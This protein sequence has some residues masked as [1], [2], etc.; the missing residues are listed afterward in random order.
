MTMNEGMVICYAKVLEEL[1]PDSA[2]VDAADVNPMRFAQN[3]RRE[4]GRHIKI[5]SEHKAD[6]RYPIVSAASILAKVKRDEE[7]QLLEEQ[8]GQEIGSG[9]PS[10]VRTQRFLKNWVKEHGSLPTFVRHSWRTAQ[11]VLK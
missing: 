4:Y 1:K 5:I 7:V 8:I 9:Y 2:F 10:D 11:A 3:V 6:V